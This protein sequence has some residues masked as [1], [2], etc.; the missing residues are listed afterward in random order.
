MNLSTRFS[1]ALWI[2]ILFCLVG[3][4]NGGCIQSNAEYDGGSFVEVGQ[5]ISVLCNGTQSFSA[6]VKNAEGSFS[7]Y[8]GTVSG[9]C[10]FQD[11]SKPDPYGATQ[12]YTCSGAVGNP[13]GCSLTVG[14]AYV[15]GFASILYAFDC[16]QVFDCVSWCEDQGLCPGETCLECAWDCQTT[17]CP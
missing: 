12:Y 7:I 14:G 15:Y 9:T 2:P 5:E 8:I 1:S 10:D 3:L 4:M 13:E 17:L 6:P 11:F 16:H